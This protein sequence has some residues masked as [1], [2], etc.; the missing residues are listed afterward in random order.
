MDLSN[1][2]LLDMQPLHLQ[3]DNFIKA[4]CKALDPYFKK[5]SDNIKTVYIYGRLDELEE[6]EIDSL[7][8]QFHVDFYDYKLSLDKKRQ[9]VKNSIKLHKIKG[10]PA[11]VEEV[12]STVF[13]RTKLKE[14]FEY[15]GKPFFFSMDIDITDRGASPGELKK[16]DDLINA[17]K[18]KRSW[19]DILNIYYSVK[20]QVYYGLT[21]V[22]GESITVYPWSPK[23]IETRGSIT[24][25]IVQ[26]K[27]VEQIS[28][29]PKR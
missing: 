15:G 29:Y 18:N 3:N 27:D 22:Q 12:A 19:V 17:Y 16:L 7:A 6:D 2:S 8:D 28:I 14:W 21:L 26:S 5:L 11:A 20:G 4:L 25:P 9:L 10:T 1:I 13:G 23:D 24:V